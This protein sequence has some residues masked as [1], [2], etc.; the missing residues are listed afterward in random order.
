M[1]PLQHTHVGGGPLRYGEANS[2]QQAYL[3]VRQRE[4]ALAQHKLL[5]IDARTSLF[6]Q[7]TTVVVLYEQMRQDDDILGAKELH[8][9][10]QSIRQYGTTKE[11]F[12]H[13]N[14]RAINNKL[15]DIPNH[16][17]ILLTQHLLFRDI[18]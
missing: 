17:F 9:L 18:I 2:I 1:D 11:I 4:N 13:L 8:T 6:Q 5:G 10:L 15:Q 14:L 7:F 3:A 16:V 12:E